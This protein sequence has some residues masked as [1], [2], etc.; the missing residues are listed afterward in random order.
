MTTTGHLIHR[1]DTAEFPIEIREKPPLRWLE[2]GDG[3]IQSIIDLKQPGQL[4]SAV[5]RAML[6]GLLFVPA[7]QQV[8]ILGGGGGALSRYLHHRHP[9]CCGVVVERSEAV[10]RLAR[11]FFEFPTEGSGWE[12]LEDDA[13]DFVRRTD[14]TYDLIM[15]DI[16]EGL[17]SPRWL[18]DGTFLHHCRGQLST[19]GMLAINLMV[20]NADDFAHALS[21]IRRTFD[22]RTVCLSVPGHKNIIVFGFNAPPRYRNTDPIQQRL[23]ALERR[24]GLEFSDFFERMRHENPKNSGVF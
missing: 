8:L 20:D 4:P 17:C 1:E 18:T 24:W 12:L 9:A 16:A 15:M 13:R 21:L 7:P 10:A 14:N 22:L 6:A 2:F 5:A 11:R 19:Q 3:I 23:P